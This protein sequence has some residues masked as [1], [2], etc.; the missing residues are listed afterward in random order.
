MT[1]KELRDKAGKTQMGVAVEVG[2]SMIRISSWECG[3][4]KPNIKFIRALAA[5]LKCTVNELL[6]ALKV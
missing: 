4:N 6:D 2:V 5:A 1:L 3:L